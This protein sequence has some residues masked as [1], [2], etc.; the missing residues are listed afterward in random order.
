[1]KTALYIRVSTKEQAENGH[2]IAGQE[3]RLRAFAEAK[4]LS[5]IEVYKDDGYSGASL[6]R[7]E[8]QR[9]IRDVKQ[10]QISSILVYKLDRLSRS[11]KDTLHLIEEVFNRYEASLI[12]ISES[13][14]TSTAFGRAMIGI[15]SVFAQL[16]RENIRERIM[17]GKEQNAK[18]GR[19][20]GGGNTQGTIF[21]YRRKDKHWIIEPYEAEIVKEVYTLYL[22]GHGATKIRNIINQKF[23]DI[24]P[25]HTRVT[26]I[27][28]NSFYA[29]RIKHSNK[30]YEGEHEGIVSKDT[31]DMVQIFRDKRRVRTPKIKDSNFVLRGLI[32][33]DWCGKNYTSRP[34]SKNRPGR[35]DYYSCFGRF[36]AAKYPERQKC[37]NKNHRADILHELVFTQLDK[38][39]S[40]DLDFEK[41]FE[42]NDTIAVYKNKLK[43]ITKQIERVTDL[44][45]DGAIQIDILNARME[46]LNKEKKAVEENLKNYEPKNDLAAKELNKLQTT[47]FRNISNAELSNMLNI[48]IDRIVIDNNDIKIYYNFTL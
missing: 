31:F 2:S 48:L 21:G 42:D 45:I 24:F 44:Y 32:K 35:Y 12:S 38:L 3:N 14:D 40:E 28:K 19:W 22:D 7:P 41:H 26:A 17:M 5:N 33:C 47:D 27:L 16:E 37:M 25:D 10:G 34:S 1:M 13:F 6:N 29:G 4:D 43:E 11:Q 8:M 23:G 46:K 9:L 36:A 18:L 20:N 30:E 39:R 15:L